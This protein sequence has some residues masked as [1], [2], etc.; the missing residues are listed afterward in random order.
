VVLAR[1]IARGNGPA[2]ARRFFLENDRANTSNTAA[3]PGPGNGGERLLRSE[4]SY[5][6]SI[7]KI[8]QADRE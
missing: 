1:T 4:F 2:R 8:G 5:K 3:A 7:R 6:T